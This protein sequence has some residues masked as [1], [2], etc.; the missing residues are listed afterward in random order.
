M[1]FCRKLQK[2]GVPVHVDH[3]LSWQIGHVHEIVLTNEHVEKQRGDQ[4]P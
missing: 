2:A 1:Y 4:R 3:A